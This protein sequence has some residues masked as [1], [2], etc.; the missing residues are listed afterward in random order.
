MNSSQRTVTKGHTQR[1]LTS[2]DPQ[3]TTLRDTPRQIGQQVGGKIGTAFREAV[4]SLAETE[5]EYSRRDSD[6]SISDPDDNDGWDDD[7]RG[8]RR[9]PPVVNNDPR[10]HGAR[11]HVSTRSSDAVVRN[12]AARWRNGPAVTYTSATG[13]G[14]AREKG[15]MRGLP[16]RTLQW[17][18]CLRRV[19]DRR[20]DVDGD[21]FLT[22]GD[23]VAC[24]PEIGVDVHDQAAAARTLLV[25][26]DRRERGLGQA[27]FKDFVEFMGVGDSRSYRRSSGG[28]RGG[29]GSSGSDRR[30][31]SF[32]PQRGSSDFDDEVGT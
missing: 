22:L 6:D 12:R 23:L 30:R 1:R 16:I 5:Q 17:S 26:M 13:T 19:F 18:E 32:S 14:T 29:M 28:R 20:L 4:R 21:G 31:S 8:G 2:V 9:Y 27:T 3:T 11:R 7:D 15:E 24:L 10:S 25:A